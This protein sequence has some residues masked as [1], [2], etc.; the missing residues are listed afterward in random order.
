MVSLMFLL[1]MVAGGVY[2]QDEK[3]PVAPVRTKPK[4]LKELVA[5]EKAQKAAE[6]KA[7]EEEKQRQEE[8]KKRQEEAKAKREEAKAK[9]DAAI[10][11]G[12]PIPEDVA[13]YVTDTDSTIWA[14]TNV[15]QL[16]D[17][18]STRLNSSHTDSSRMPS[19]A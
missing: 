8:E 4:T 10:E 2:A 19:S 17:R 7:K 9:R 12:E 18:K 3:T 6:K 16:G 14:P 13:D 11:A 15:K 5:E 1:P